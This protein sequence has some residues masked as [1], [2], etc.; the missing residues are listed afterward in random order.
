MPE[1]LEEALQT[2][3]PVS[4]QVLHVLVPLLLRLLILGI[5]RG[6]ILEGDGA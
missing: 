4:K 1:K 3:Q 6:G 5:Q 2:A